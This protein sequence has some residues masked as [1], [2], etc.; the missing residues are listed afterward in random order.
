MKSIA[1]LAAIAVVLSFA[2][3][4]FARPVPPAAILI[5][6]VSGLTMFVLMIVQGLRRG[7]Q[8]GR[9]IDAAD[10]KNKKPE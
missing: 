6:V 1:W 2:V 10:P 7:M 5:F 3:L 8:I 9:I 4:L